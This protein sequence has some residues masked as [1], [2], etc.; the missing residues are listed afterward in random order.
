[1]ERS[2]IEDSQN[3]AWHEVGVHFLKKEKWHKKIVWFGV[4][5]TEFQRTER[6]VSA[7]EIKDNVPE[8][9]WSLIGVVGG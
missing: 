9:K 3:S 5:N 7:S 2:H 6:L 8:K 4:R 1:M